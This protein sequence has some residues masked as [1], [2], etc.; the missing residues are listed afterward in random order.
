ML[1]VCVV[2]RVEAHNVFADTGGVHFERNWHSRDCGRWI[3]QWTSSRDH[4]KVGMKFGQST[5]LN[6]FCLI[7]SCPC[8]FRQYLTYLAETSV[9]EFFWKFLIDTAALLILC[10]YTWNRLLKWPFLLLLLLL[11][12]SASSESFPMELGFH[13]GYI[14]HL[15]KFKAY[16]LNALNC[17]KFL[18]K[19]AM[20]T[21][22]T[23]IKPLNASWY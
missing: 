23:S 7:T 16:A 8:N 5:R 18:S 22:R 12:S 17:T 15:T 20:Y 13:C 9:W 21:W 11:A 10:E 3:C 19:E 14:K 1:F 6:Q 2:R 4:K